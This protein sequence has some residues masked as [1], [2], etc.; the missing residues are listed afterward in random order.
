MVAPGYRPYYPGYY[1]GGRRFF[2][3]M[4]RR[5]R[6]NYTGAPRYYQRYYRGN[7]GWGTYVPAPR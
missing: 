7:R 5:N 1:S 4:F 2:G 3:R 6:V